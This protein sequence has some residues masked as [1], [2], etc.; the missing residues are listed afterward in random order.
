M[1]DNAEFSFH[2]HKLT[3]DARR[4]ALFTIAIW[5]GTVLRSI[6]YAQPLDAALAAFR[7]IPEEWGREATGKEVCRRHSGVR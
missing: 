1:L 6:C 5:E 4:P 3:A 2:V 7:K